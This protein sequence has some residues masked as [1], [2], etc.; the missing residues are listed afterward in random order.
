MLRVIGTRLF[1][2]LSVL[3]ILSVFYL[4]SGIV[5][6]FTYLDASMFLF[7]SWPALLRFVYIVFALFL[8]IH[9]GWDDYK[10][11]MRGN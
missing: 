1:S 10:A 9:A 4:L 2:T 8:L 6:S 11:S 7:T 3:G 5:A